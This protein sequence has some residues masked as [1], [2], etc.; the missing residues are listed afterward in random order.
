MRS[1]GILDIVAVSTAA[2]LFKVS[3]RSGEESRITDARTERTKRR[4]ASGFNVE[5]PQPHGSSER[6]NR[7][8][9]T[10]NNQNCKLARKLQRVPPDSQG[11]V[12]DG[13]IPSV[14][15][16]TGR[17]QFMDG[18]TDTVSGKVSKL[19]VPFSQSSRRGKLLAFKVKLP[20][21]QSENGALLPGRQPVRQ[22]DC[23]ASGIDSWFD[24]LESSLES[25][26]F[27][28][29]LAGRPSGK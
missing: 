13:V 17:C 27:F 23:F 4:S 14:L 5:H 22:S 7:C 29:V 15:Q 11:I 8:F 6:Y 3:A 28:P 21:P 1:L 26:L 2:K 10:G 24:S 19:L 20:A 9:D 18:L 25:T 16:V 12:P